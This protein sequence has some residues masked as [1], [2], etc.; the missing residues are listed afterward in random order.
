MKIDTLGVQA[1]VALAE[2]GSFHGAAT[3]LN[4]TQAALSRRL[5]QLESYLGVRL[6]ERTTRT[7]ALTAI[8]EH[9]LP[10]ARRLLAELASALREIRETGK[11]QRGDVTIAC[12]PTMG[13]RYL[14]RLFERYA[15]QFPSNRIKVLDHSSAGVE[16][17]VQRR[18]AEFGISVAGGYEGGL[19]RQPIL[20]DRMV[21]VCR[22]DHPLAR[23]RRLRW[24]ELQSHRLIF[25]G[26]GSSN[27]PLLDQA[28]AEQ[29]LA[30][31]PFYEVQRSSTAVGLA[32]QGMGLA[33]VPSMAMQD[34]MSTRLKVIDLV[35]PTVSR[36]FELLLRPQAQLSPAARALYDMMLAR[37]PFE[38]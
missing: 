28:L 6:V 18:E 38:T 3:A 13:V 33:I 22:T 12:V 16:L 25:P 4:I 37:Q 30:L 8:G 9:F 17:A 15:E 11:A 21:A 36:V 10:Q 29:Q 1:F 32:A 26:Q 20:Q 24:R 27:R 34:G 23:R 35:E 31:D 19:Q 7:L 2:R 5:I 14:P